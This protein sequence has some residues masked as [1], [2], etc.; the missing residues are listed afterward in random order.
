M[1]D[2]PKLAA[3][4]F[5]QGCSCS[6]SVVKAAYESKIIDQNLDPELLNLITSPFSGAMGTH[7]CL[8][9]AVAGSQ[10]VLG[11]LFGRK[12][13]QDDPYKIKEIAAEFL[14]KFK[15]KRKVACCRVLRAK[16]KD[17]PM[18]ARMNCGN[19]VAECA[20]ILQ[21]MIIEKTSKPVA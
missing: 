21:S 4:L 10:I 1:Q 12:E 2:F 11:L 15:E 5:M 14:D 13:T 3:D 9:G 16:Y 19:I 20:Q 7:E 6:E 18:E 8:C 17:N